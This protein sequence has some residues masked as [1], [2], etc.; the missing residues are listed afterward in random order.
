MCGRVGRNYTN[1]I[2]AVAPGGLSSLSMSA[3]DWWNAA[4]GAKT[5]PYDPGIPKSCRPL[6]LG[7][8]GSYNTLEHATSSDSQVYPVVVSL[9][10][11]PKSQHNPIL[12]LPAELLSYDP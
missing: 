1:P 2:I 4:L 3:Y 6:N 10:S 12:S 7:D 11:V 8:V 5:L 9:T